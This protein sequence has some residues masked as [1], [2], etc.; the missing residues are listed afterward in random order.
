MLALEREHLFKC[1]ARAPHLPH[2]IPVP[3]SP[4][5]MELKAGLTARTLWS[6]DPVVPLIYSKESPPKT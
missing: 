5:V 2:L 1:R 4:C 3:E 6:P